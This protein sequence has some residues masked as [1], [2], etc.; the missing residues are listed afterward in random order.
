LPPSRSVR[1]VAL[2]LLA[3]SLGPWF[4][5]AA[6]LDQ[7]GQR[8][9]SEGG[10]DAIVVAGC[11]VDPGGVPS[12]AL[13]ARTELAVALFEEGLAP[14]LAFT[15]GLGENPPTEA[16]AAAAHARALG[17]PDA[18]IVLEDRSTSTEENARFLAEDQNYQRVLL[19]SDAYHVFRARQV[20]ARHFPHV[21]AAGSV[22]TPW[23]R[24]RGS[25]REVL[26]IGLYRA[27]GRITLLG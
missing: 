20:F 22:A 26:A 27:K 3:G 25:L 13:R 17:V 8:V 18:A 6:A 21:D 7:L 12:P 1:R 14:E 2:L 24:L 23:E 16:Q 5:A 9:P 10:W 15:G 4:L 11:R 19:V